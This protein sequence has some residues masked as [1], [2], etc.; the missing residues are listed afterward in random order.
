MWQVSEPGEPDAGWL[1]TDTLERQARVLRQERLVRLAGAAFAYSLSIL[2]LDAWIV[3][4]IAATD[5]AAEVRMAQILNNIPRLVHDRVRRWEFV[6]LVFVAEASFAL[7]PAL[8]WHLGDPLVKALAMGIVAGSM[9][10]LLTVRAIHLPSGLAAALAVGIMIYVSNAWFWIAQG[11]F[12]GLALTTAIVTVWVGYC[13]SALRSNHGL[14]RD[15]AIAARRAA[16][17]D[18]AKGRFLAQVSHEVRTPLNAILGLGHAE[19][20]RATDPGAVERLSVMVASADGLSRLLDDILDLTAIEA[21]RMPIRPV[22]TEPAAEIAAAA[23]LWRPAI[24]QAGLTLVVETDGDLAAP[25]LI[26]RERLGQCLSNL[27]SN[28][29]RHTPRGTITLRARAERREETRWLDAEVVDQGPGVP[30]ALHERLFEPFAAADGRPGHGIGLSIA[31][32]MVRQMGGDLTLEPSVDGASGARFRLRLPLPEAARA[33]P[34]PQRAAAGTLAGLRVLIVDD[35]AA[36][37]MVAAACL[38]ALG[39]EAM[40]VGSG[41]AALD[42]VARER[43]HAVL[44]DMNMPGMDGIETFRRLRAHPGGGSSLP[45]VA[46]TADSMPGHRSRF[47]AAGLD[48]YLAKPLTPERLAEALAP[49]V[50]RRAA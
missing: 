49:V 11:D 44:L 25:A 9:M 15:M 19:L 29:L 3:F 41:P 12:R 14:N 5:L 1:L 26:D 31:R 46:M 38:R 32:A 24:E 40:E 10:H 13:V 20:R 30:P 50:G 34:A 18:A 7:P 16:E 22:A 43:W 17:A 37:R 33:A 47:L 21:G 6:G 23:A 36:N 8:L 45:V 2:F 39:A 28:A 48:G 42:A 35:V 27:L 4:A